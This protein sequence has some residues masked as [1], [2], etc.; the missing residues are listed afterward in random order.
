[1]NASQGGIAS[2]G[3][4][5]LCPARRVIERDGVPLALGDRALDILIAL[6]ERPGE[7]VSHRDLIAH[8]WRDLIVT[9]GN[10]RVHMSALRKALGDG[11]GGAHYIENVTGQGYCFVAQI[12]YEATTRSPG[13]SVGYPDAARKRLVLPPRLSRMVGREQIVHSIRNDLLAERF[14][15]VIGPGGIGKTTVA[16]CVAHELLEEF[17]G[18]IC[19]VDLGAVA[20][21]QLVAATI[22]SS[23]GLSVQTADALPTLLDYLRTLRIL[24]VFD[25]CEHV[26]DAIAALAET[27]FRET[28]GVHLLTTS[29]EALRV[30]GERI[31]WLPALES[32][33]PQ[34][35]MK[36]AD[37]LEFPAVQLFM[38]RATA[39]GG[40]FELDDRNAP[41]VAG[42]CGRLEGIALAIELAAGRAGTHGIAATADLLNKNLGLDWHGRRTAHP[43]HQT[44][45]ALLD[46]SY[47][48]LPESERLALCRLSI[49]V[50]TFTIEAAT[51]VAN[52]GASEADTLATLDALVAKCL[53]SA[54]PEDDGSVRY[55]LL[56]TTRI[57]ALEKLRANGEFPLAAR[58]HAE[59][60]VKLLNAQHG[61]LIDLEY[62][63]RAH[64][65]RDHLGDMRGALEWCFRPGEITDPILAVDLAAAAAPVFF[66]LSL[67]NESFKWSAAGLAALDETTRGGRREMLLQSTWAISSMWVRGNTQ[68]VLGA[69][70]RGLELADPLDE[71]SQRLRML[72]T[73]HLFMTR[74][75]D[76]RGALVAAEAWDVA[77][78]QAG[79]ATCLAISDLMQGVARH[80]VGNQAAA[81]RH[82]DAGF[83]RAGER[84][85]QL[86]GNDHRVRALIV[87][88]RVLWLSGLPERATDTA[89]Q[90]IT[91][92]MRSG[93]PLD[94]CFALLFTSPVY[95]W[96]GHWDAAQDVLT[97]L[98]NHPH[99]P[100]LKPFHSSATA[101]QGA[102]LIGRKE[103]KRGVPM[104]QAAL[105]DM[106]AERQNVIRT[107]AAL[108][109]AD[110]LMTTGRIEEA[111]TAIRD[112]RHEAV[113]SGEAVLLPELLRVQAKILLAASPANTDRAVRLLV[114]AHRIALR[115]SA[116]SWDLRVAMDLAHIMLRERD[117]A[118][119]RSVL[120]DAY[121]RFTE[122]FAT[123][124]LVAATELLHEIDPPQRVGGGHIS[125]N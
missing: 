53:V 109:L 43:R 2:F 84:N 14:V 64:A 1:M 36:A 93:K 11:D 103:A 87:L 28:A 59:H 17:A 4:F 74:L 88:S 90:A 8:V 76:F 67:L 68:D 80:F 5:R 85:L 49:L 97:Q 16:V 123:H 18:A 114:R 60:V 31:Y 98:V 89:R 26:V 54:Q 95:L 83:A 91:T 62:T 38:E 69:I 45:R 10:L 78:K 104:L 71:P 3:P 44:L 121:H 12:T 33:S 41:I 117:D 61:G 86:C 82:F 79:D 100:I 15:T 52:E 39:G 27:I 70:A 66:E 20:D 24:L 106:K 19:F 6:A 112:A 51:A 55:R 105:A 110:G 120:R 118:T 115:Q 65:L 63:G 124:D 75:A 23:L 37:I 50:G 57:Y 102:L 42:I 40:R 108:W 116:F 96:C 92:A 111:D 73:R 29:R 30:E 72:A 107:L 9:P 34:S 13:R 99:W 46:W 47:G 25:N 122:G 94:T 125:M 7:I 32:P 22:A 113:R 119:A 101:L 56:E 58:R 81:R 48:F 21:G 77:A 35:R